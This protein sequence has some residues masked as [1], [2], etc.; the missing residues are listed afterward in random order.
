AAV[1]VQYFASAI[2]VDDE[3][4]KRDFL[5]FVRATVEGSPE[6]AE[7]LRRL[8]DPRVGD[9]EKDQLV[10]AAVPGIDPAAVQQRKDPR[11]SDA[12]KEAK[13]DLV[14]PNLTDITVRAI[15]EPVDPKPGEAV[16]HKYLPYHRPM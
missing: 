2:T 16:E 15:A 1:A 13:L 11:L 6:A 14:R 5:E 8:R 10:R 4:P 9:A 3:Q 12:E 7:L